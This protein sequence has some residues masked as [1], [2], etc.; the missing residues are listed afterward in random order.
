MTTGGEMSL[1]CGEKKMDKKRSKGVTFWGWIYI[2]SGIGGIWQALH[3]YPQFIKSYGFSLLICSVA[4]SIAYLISGFCVL[5][6]NDAARKAV[7]ALGILSILLIPIYFKPMF[8]FAYS[9]DFYSKAK[10]RI[11]EQTKPEYQQKAL[12]ELEKTQGVAKMLPFILITIIFLVPYLILEIIPIYFF[13]RYKV[14][15]QF[16]Q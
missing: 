3:Y 1:F 2:I 16:K 13:T 15:E 4:I 11:V 5:K 10:Q 8:K 14:K 6:L 7:I 12:K 9:Q